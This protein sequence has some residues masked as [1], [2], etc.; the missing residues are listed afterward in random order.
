MP[1][2]SLDPPD[3]SDTVWPMW[4]PS[5]PVSGEL[6]SLAE[7]EVA[8]GGGKP[9]ARWSWFSGGLTSQSLFSCLDWWAMTSL[10]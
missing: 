9:K 5:W 4:L 6:G 3:N 8:C 2:M 7:W 1:C 10:S